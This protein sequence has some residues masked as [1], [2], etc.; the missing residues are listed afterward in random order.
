MDDASCVSSRRSTKG[1]LRANED[2]NVITLPRQVGPNS[3]ASLFCN[4][5][6]IESRKKRLSKQIGSVCWASMSEYCQLVFDSNILISDL[7]LI[8]VEECERNNF[9]PCN[10]VGHTSASFSCVRAYVYYISEQPHV[11]YCHAQ[12]MNLGLSFG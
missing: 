12:D 11:I 7:I 4:P 10:L 6:T 3:N 5:K 8:V 9:C 1:C 2:R